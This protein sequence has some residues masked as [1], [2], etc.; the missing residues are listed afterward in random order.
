MCMEIELVG[1]ACDGRH[2]TI[3]GDPTNPTPALRIAENTPLR[4]LDDDGEL[5]SPEDTVKALLSAFQVV[6]YYRDTEPADFFGTPLW[7]YRR[8][9]KVPA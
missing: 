1:G 9:P 6:V 5:L 4:L 2:V 8:D 3:C 7:R